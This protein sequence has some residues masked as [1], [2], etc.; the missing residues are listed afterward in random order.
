MKTKELKQLE[1]HIKVFDS[2]AKGSNKRK[3]PHLQRTNEGQKQNQMAKNLFI[4]H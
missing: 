1:K 4:N 2:Q 3:S